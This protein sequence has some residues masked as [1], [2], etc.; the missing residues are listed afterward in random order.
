MSNLSALDTGIVIAWIAFMIIIGLW[1]SYTSKKE[2]A[3]DYF[4]A[5]KALPWWAVGGSL[6]A[7]NIS[8][9]Q[10]IGMSGSGYVIGLGIAAYELMAAVTLIIV[11]KYFLPVFIEKEIYTM[12]QFLEKR[13]DS[14]V[15]TGLAFFW[16][17]LFVLVNITSVLYLGSLAIVQIVGI[18]MMYAIIGLAIYSASFSVLGGLKAV[19]LTDVIQVVALILGGLVASNMVLNAVSDGGG[20]LAGLGQLIERAPE[21]FDMILDKSNPEYINLPGIGVLVGGMWV[22]NL[23]YWGTNQYIIQRSLACKSLE[24][25]Q[26]GTASAALI[27]VILPLIVVIPGIAAYVLGADI[28]KPDEAYPWVISN[29]VGVGF[30][31]IALAALIAAI[32]SSIASIVNSAATIFSLDLYKPLVMK[33]NSTD[34]DTP[35]NLAQKLTPSQEKQ[36][37]KVGKWSSLIFIIVGMIIAPQLG[38]LEQAFQYIQEYTGFISPG[39]LAIFVLGLFWR[40]T[41]TNAALAG[42]ILAIPLSVA[43][44]F[45]TPGVPFLDR[46]GYCFLLISLM[47]IIISMMENKGDDPKAII[48]ERKL[49]KT[50]FLFNFLSV[51][52]I[53]LV[54]LIYIIFW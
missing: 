51:V 46:M 2:T 30:K 53:A 15:R 39:V 44:K 8:A 54:A 7:A 36:L 1:I 21:K 38:N 20:I 45:L 42:V 41:S 6:I 33:V 43:F 27:K 34:E 50:N 19:A 3:N 37:V 10:F 12:P 25:S 4:L 40:R 28:S 26:V 5:S 52:V 14:R 49:F 16:V 23:Y 11:A 48:Y 35:D 18:P 29:Y 24:E 9:E 13:F 17:L 22:A 31:G 32:G 47:M